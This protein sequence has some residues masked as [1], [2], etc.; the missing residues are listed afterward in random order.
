MFRFFGGER[1][2]GRWG[3]SRRGDSQVCW[4]KV[5]IF[6]EILKMF[7]FLGRVAG[8]AGEGEARCGMEGVREGER[9]G[10]WVH[11]IFPPP[12]RFVPVHYTVRKPNVKRRRLVVVPSFQFSVS[13]FQWP[14][15]GGMTKFGKTNEG[16]EGQGSLLLPNRAPAVGLYR[17]GR[18]CRRGRRGRGGDGGAAFGAFVA[19]EAGFLGTQVVTALGAPTAS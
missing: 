3:E 11:G 16:R 5:R 19:G 15:E 17:L 7:R 14:R 2:G 6:R 10:M 12:A 1:S 9:C 18:G 8:V 13:S 4:R